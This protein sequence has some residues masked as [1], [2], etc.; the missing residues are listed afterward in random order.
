MIM[1]D[2]SLIKRKKSIPQRIVRWSLWIGIVILILIV[3]QVTVLAFPQLLLNDNVQ[4]GT[5]S[6]Y[7]DNGPD[8]YFRQLAD[9]A[10][11]RL[12]LSGFYDSSRVDRVFF[13]QSDGL[14]S[15]FAR[16]SLVTP[17]AQ[18]FNL[19]IFGNSFI[20]GKRIERLAGVTGGNPE[21]NIWEGS[22]AHIIAHEIGHQYIMDRIGRGVWTRLPHWKQEG[23]PEYIANI[24]L[25]QSDTLNTMRRRI[26]ILED[27]NARGGGND[28]WARIHYRAEL[29]IEYLF[30]VGGYTLEDIIDDSVTMNNAYDAMMTWSG[31]FNTGR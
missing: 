28:S 5:V 19:S 12:R 10:D 20:N 30:D 17:S 14:F 27:N 26:E 23:L 13:C 4:V 7:Y 9:E 21:Y 25:M 6:I 15:F 18:G 3:L 24:G 22:A 2:S 1:P 8:V 29:L 11:R 31:A 16:L